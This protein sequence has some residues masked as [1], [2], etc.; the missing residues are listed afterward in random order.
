MYPKLK[1]ILAV[2]KASKIAVMLK[3]IFQLWVQKVFPSLNVESTHATRAIQRQ[4]FN[5]WQNVA[6]L[7]L[8][9]SLL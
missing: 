9:P 2:E 5:G 7:V 8:W 4:I 1:N 3:N 6:T